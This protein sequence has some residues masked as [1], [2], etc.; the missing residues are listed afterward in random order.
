[1]AN[2]ATLDMDTKPR[3]GQMIYSKTKFRFGQD[4]LP[5]MQASDFY[6]YL[7]KETGWHP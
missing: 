1:M 5:A 6:K 3:D 7:D 2:S 4:W